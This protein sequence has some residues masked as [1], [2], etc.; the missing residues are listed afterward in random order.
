ML[1]SEEQVMEAGQEQ[2]STLWTLA[3][4]LSCLGS[5]SSAS[6]VAVAAGTRPKTEV[7]PPPQLCEGF[8]P[9]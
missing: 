2:L 4:L 8:S 5:V 6:L 1:L 9:P 3:V 7:P